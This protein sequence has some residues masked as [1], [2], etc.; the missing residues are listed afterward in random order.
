MYL[1]SFVALYVWMFVAGANE[2]EG[3]MSWY[4]GTNEILASNWTNVNVLRDKKRFDY[5]HL[6]VYRQASSGPYIN[7]FLT[8]SSRSIKF[9]GR[10]IHP[11]LL[12]TRP[13]I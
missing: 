1:C 12:L 2:A 9:F 5:C 6:T 3:A 7:K 11:E 13:A 8:E 4:V 10:N